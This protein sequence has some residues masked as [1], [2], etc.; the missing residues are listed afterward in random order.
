MKYR[1]VHQT[2]YDY[3]QAVTLCHNEAHL[4]PRDFDRQRCLSHRVEIQPAPLTQSERVDFFGNPVYYFAIEEPHTRLLVTATSEVQLDLGGR[5]GH[6]HA[7]S[8]W[9]EAAARVRVETT[10]ANL[11]ARQYLVDSPLVTATPQIKSYAAASLGPGRSLVDAVHDLMTRIHTDFAYDP[12]FTSVATPLSVVFK[13][14]RGVCQ[15]FA[16]LSIACLRSH[17]LPARY[18]SG[19]IQTLPAPGQEKLQGADAS[20]AWFSVYEPEAG[21]LDYDPTNNQVPMDQ[22]ITTAWGRDYGD[23]T[24]LKGVIFGGGKSHTAKVAVD[25]SVLE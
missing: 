21:W 7:S 2:A 13:H 22:H 9:E 16:H 10:E 19:Y 11:E 15:D 8:T 24:P 3:P 6:L 1:V 25:V 17:G 12:G 4:R 23:I 20:H 14:R 5:Q 18:A